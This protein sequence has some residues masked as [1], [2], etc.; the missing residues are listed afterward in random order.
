MAQNIVVHITLQD[1]SIGF[2]EIAPFTDLT[3]E[4]VE[5]SLTTAKTLAASLLG[6]SV[7]NYR[8]SAHQIQDQAP[9]FPATRCGIETAILDAFCRS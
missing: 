8:R 3:G 6:T 9:N 2:G 4:T 1:G 7:R 5:A